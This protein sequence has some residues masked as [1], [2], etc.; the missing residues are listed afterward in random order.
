MTEPDIS[1]RPERN[2]K[3]VVHTIVKTAISA[4]PIPFVSGPVAELFNF[5][6]TPSLKKRDDEWIESVAKRLKALEKKVEGFKI[7]NLCENE[8]FI[9]TLIHASQ[10]AIRS[11]QK[12]KLEALRNAVLNAAMPNAPEE[13]L[14]LM[15]LNFVD[16]FTP[17]HLRMLKILN[18]YEA[19][20]PQNR[21][22]GV[23]IEFVLKSEQSIALPVHKVCPDLWEHQK[24]YN[25]ALIDLRI[26]GLA[27]IRMTDQADFLEKIVYAQPTKLGEE[28][29]DFIAS[30]IT[31]KDNSD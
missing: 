4:I 14:Q 26:R 12:Q 16:S 17:F 15:F 19:R 6:I 30:P 22:T 27:E 29:L 2:A 5:V 20:R 8:S 13:D 3:D 1:K 24:Y 10:A 31:S 9:S 21:H 28:F 23:R 18:D 7:E 25:Q 11:H